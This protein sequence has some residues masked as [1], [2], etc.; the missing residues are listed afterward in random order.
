MS[1]K[2]VQTHGVSLQWKKGWSCNCKVCLTHH[3]SFFN[4]LDAVSP[5]QGM[6]SDL[7][8]LPPMVLLSS[9][10]HK[11]KMTGSIL[12]HIRCSAVAGH[13][14]SAW[15]SWNKHKHLS[16][17]MWMG[18]TVPWMQFPYC[19]YATAA[20]RIQGEICR[21]TPLNADISSIFGATVCKLN[22]PLSKW[23][24]I[25]EDLWGFGVLKA[26]GQDN[27]S[28]RYTSEHFLLYKQWLIT[29]LSVLRAIHYVWRFMHV[30]PIRRLHPTIII[31]ELALHT[32]Q[33]IALAF[34]LVL[35][36]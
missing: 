4:S 21:E 8:C 36:W 6:L 5:S 31:S 32:K 22:T 28:A 7:S 1:L 23:E 16:A 25:C 30:E 17:S 12:Q 26:N 29:L 27:C 10:I 14:Y 19:A 2:N 18:D 35:V 33:L 34:W 13:T 20:T 9:E 15:L 24:I 11:S 3:I